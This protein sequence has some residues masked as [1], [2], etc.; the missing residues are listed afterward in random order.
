MGS[1]QGM[2][3]LA[4]RKLDRSAVYRPNPTIYTI[5]IG[6]RHQIHWARGPAR[7]TRPTGHAPQQAGPPAP[8][9][10]RPPVRTAAPTYES[11][12]GGAGTATIAAGVAGWV[13]WWVVA[14]AAAARRRHRHAEVRD[15]GKHNRRLDIHTYLIDRW[16]DWC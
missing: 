16:N 3:C 1:D 2:L 13:W 14:A 11:R 5:N 12:R 10:P 8:F 15:R 6:Q 9:P 4:K 7:R